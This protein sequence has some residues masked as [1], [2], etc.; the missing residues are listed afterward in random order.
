[1]AYDVCN[2]LVV[3]Q[4]GVCWQGYQCRLEAFRVIGAEYILA[5]GGS[6]GPGPELYV[7]DS[8]QN[9]SLRCF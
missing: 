4:G 3:E 1:M 9:C 6:S 8:N 5:F 2:L 7:R